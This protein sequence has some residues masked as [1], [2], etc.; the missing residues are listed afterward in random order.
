M[1]NTTKHD[2]VVLHR[3]KV[4]LLLT[5]LMIKALEEM[6]VELA[7]YVETIGDNLKLLKV[8]SGKVWLPFSTDSMTE[9]LFS[10]YISETKGGAK[11]ESD[12]IMYVPEIAVGSPGTNTN[13]MPDIELIKS[14]HNKL[15]LLKSEIA[16]KWEKEH[17]DKINEIMKRDNSK[18]RE[19]KDQV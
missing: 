3:A 10:D 8:I 15:S 7:D 4:A 12:Y 19:K 13:G 9:T 17:D 5:E 16:G 11:K 1:P 14:E 6:D 18:W 2:Y